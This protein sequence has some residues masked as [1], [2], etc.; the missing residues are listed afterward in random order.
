[1]RSEEKNRLHPSVYF[2]IPAPT[3]ISPGQRFRFEHYLESLKAIGFKI[4]LSPFY[5]RKAWDS[6]YQPGNILKKGFYVLVGFLKRWTDLVRLLP[7]K[8][9]FVYREAA[10]IGPPFFEWIVAKILR[11]KIILDFDDAIWVPVSSEQNRLAR[12]MRCFWKT[13]HICK[14]SYKVSTGNLFLANY[15]AKYCSKTVVIPTVVNTDNNHNR[16]Q[17]HDTT[18]PVI[19]W[20]GT[21]STL[22]YLD[23]VLPV[24]RMLQEKYDFTFIVI[25]NKDPKL[26]LKNYRFLQWNKETEIQDLLNL[27]IGLMP[28]YDNPIERG[29]CGFKA[30]QYMSLGIP[31]VV[32]SVGVNTEIVRHGENGYV[33]GTEQEWITY[34][35]NLLMNKELRKEF[36]NAGRLR[37]EKNYSVKATLPDFIQLFS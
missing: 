1:M 29:K 36:G 34:I 37:I 21:F 26:P 14:W 31:A 13:A 25:A 4:K 18:R 6:L 30:I 23:I 16:L 5:N 2:I 12:N 20:T 19:G 33:A 7:Y 24:I 35:R 28:L 9:V 32:S 17:Q 27:H 11:K 3:G 10:P 22:K 8:Y 15:A